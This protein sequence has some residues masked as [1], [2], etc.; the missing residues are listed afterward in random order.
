MDIMI[1]QINCGACEHAKQI[2]QHFSFILKII[3]VNIPEAKQYIESYN[4]KT[5]PFF[6]TGNGHTCNNVRDYLKTKG[7]II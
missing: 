1:T 3:D 6:I 5:L 2:L 4:I 7:V